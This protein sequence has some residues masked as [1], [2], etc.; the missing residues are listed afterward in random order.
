MGDLFNFVLS[1]LAIGYSC[2]LAITAL[3]FVFDMFKV[4]IKWVARRWEKKSLWQVAVGIALLSVGAGI[5]WP[6]KIPWAIL[7]CGTIVLV[8]AAF[9]IGPIYY[10]IRAYRRESSKVRTSI[11]V[12]LTP[13]LFMIGWNW[14]RLLFGF[15]WPLGQ[16]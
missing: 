11:L 6:T 16:S 2:V 10:W 1:C 3:Y 15:G 4:S 13:A 7:G 14:M 9:N 8:V 5:F 12:V